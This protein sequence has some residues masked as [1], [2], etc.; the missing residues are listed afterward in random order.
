MSGLQMRKKTSDA[1]TLL[2]ISR[3]RT[4][5]SASLHDGLLDFSLVTNDGL[6]HVL[7]GSLLLLDAVN[8]VHEW[9]ADEKENFGRANTP[10]DFQNQN[11]AECKSTLRNLTWS[12][13]SF[14]S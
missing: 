1:P 3:T 14:S 5:P 10:Y 6:H 9:I 4:L 2:T 8:H 12:F 11:I 13:W 7:K